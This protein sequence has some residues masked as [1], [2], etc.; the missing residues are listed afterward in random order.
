MAEEQE[1]LAFDELSKLS[2]SPTSES[3]TADLNESSL[4]KENFNIVF[5]GHVG[6]FVFVEGKS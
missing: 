2:I 1:N 3:S 6:K 5:C 4:K